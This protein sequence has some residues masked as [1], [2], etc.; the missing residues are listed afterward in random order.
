MVVEAQTAF[1][2]GGGVQSVAIGVLVAQGRLPVPDLSAIV[3]TGREVQTTWD[4]LH[5]VLNPYLMAERG[6]RV[7]V[8]PHTFARVDLFD[9]D[10]TTLMPAYTTTGRL[11]SFCSGE[12]KRDAMERWL[13]SKGVKSCTQWLGFSLDEQRRAT[14]K[15]HRPWCRPVYPLLDLRMTR[16]DCIRLIERAGLPVPS[17]SRCWM[18]PHQNAEEW[19]EVKNSPTEWAAA[20]ALDEQIRESDQAG[21]VYL[22]ASRKP[23]ALVDPLSEETPS[24]FR[25]CEDAGCFT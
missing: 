9:K 6:I 13:R 4:Y 23:L 24:L 1:S 11:S 7:E 22:H 21:D 10:G 25:H 5:G 14:G 3:D 17:K 2:C 12:W 16:W 15:A 19:T 8:V 20:V 18:C